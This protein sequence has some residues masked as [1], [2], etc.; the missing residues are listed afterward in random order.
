M[1]LADRNAALVLAPLAAQQ[2]DRAYALYR[3]YLVHFGVAPS[4]P[5]LPELLAGL[6]REPWFGFQL[7]TVGREDAGFCVVT[8][9]W[10]PLAPCLAWNLTDLY[11]EP[12]FRARGLGGEMLRRLEAEALRQGIG[13]LYVNADRDSADFYRKHGWRPFEY[14]YLYKEL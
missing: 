11:L 2:F 6:L 12:Q 4:E 10:S 14:R 13:K 7:A 9:T 8:R 5:E 3:A 1:S